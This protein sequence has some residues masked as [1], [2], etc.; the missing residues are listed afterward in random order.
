MKSRLV[1]S[2]LIDALSIASL[3]FLFNFPDT[4]NPSTGQSH[5]TVKAVSISIGILIGISLVAGLLK[6]FV[7]HKKNILLP[8]G[9]YFLSNKSTIF[10]KVL[11]RF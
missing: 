10:M 3:I 9:L 11:H 6:Y 4:N 8:Q 2:G 5:I 1:H 7:C